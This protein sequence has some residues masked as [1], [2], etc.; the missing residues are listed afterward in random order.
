[1][2]EVDFLNYMD[3]ELDQ[4]PAYQAVDRIASHIRRVQPQVVITFGPQGGYGHPDHIAI[5]Q[6]T[7]A[8]IVRAADSTTDGPHVVSKFYYMA[9]DENSWRTF[10]TA[11]KSLTSRVDGVERRSVPWPNW[12]ITTEVDTSAHW[13]TVWRA[14]QCHKTQ[15]SVYS[16]LADL[17][18]EQHRTLWGRQT[19]YRVFSAVN[20]GRR[21][22]TDLFE[23][24]R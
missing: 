1:M 16:K 2:K 21:R 3:A 5:S 19:F 4:A 17:T 20:G 18:P 9:S 12:C 8:A 13:Q 15:I 24:L 23:G 22:E 7:A 11:F 14:V 10:E 6:F